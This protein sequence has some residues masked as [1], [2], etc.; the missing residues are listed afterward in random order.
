MRRGNT[1][2]EDTSPCLTIVWG[3]AWGLQ[4]K[5]GTL[6]WIFA[7]NAVD[8]MENKLA[9][10]SAGKVPQALRGVLPHPL[11][12][13]KSLVSNYTEIMLNARQV[14]TQRQ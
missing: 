5:E 12:R 10:Q 3:R 1:S 11:A 4:L 2:L 6:L 14:K 7:H 9:T 8:I 13:N